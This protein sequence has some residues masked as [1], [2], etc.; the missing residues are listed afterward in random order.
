[1]T[2]RSAD[3]GWTFGESS[4]RR[5]PP[6]RVTISEVAVCISRTFSSARGMSTAGVLPFPGHFGIKVERRVTGVVQRCA[7]A[8]VGGNT[9]NGTG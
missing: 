9:D 5:G 3:D 7:A 8:K 6:E 2:R 4:F 1:M